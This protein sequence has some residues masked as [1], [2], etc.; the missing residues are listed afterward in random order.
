LISQVL[1]PLAP[2]LASTSRL[3]LLFPPLL[4]FGYGIPH[5]LTAFPAPLFCPMHKNLSHFFPLFFNLLNSR[6]GC[7]L[8]R[9][10]RLLFFL[11]STVTVSLSTNLK[12]PLTFGS[13]VVL[14]PP[15]AGRFSHRFLDPPPPSP[16][17]L[18]FRDAIDR[19]RVFVHNFLAL[20]SA[21][22]SNSGS[23]PVPVLLIPRPIF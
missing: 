2:V 12:R 1:R 16:F 5:L 8:V 4:P 6:S 7:R 11:T 14:P 3:D 9:T 23:G 22:I 10:Q 19:R 13:A 15:P 18:M 21:L 20:G 17:F